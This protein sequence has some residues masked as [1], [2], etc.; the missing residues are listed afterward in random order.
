MH[1]HQRGNAGEDGGDGGLEMFGRRRAPIPRFRWLL[2]LALAKQLKLLPG[3]KS[4]IFQVLNKHTIKWQMRHDSRLLNFLSL[5]P[6]H[7]R[8]EKKLIRGNF[9]LAF[10]YICE[11]S[12]RRTFSSSR[13]W[14]CQKPTLSWNQA[15][16]PKNP[17]KVSGSFPKLKEK[18]N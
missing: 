6:A 16:S 18:E 8:W 11:D 1:Q 10:I 5:T 13:K 2:A 17:W 12:V 4:N 7:I 3:A 14:G 9:C 15:N